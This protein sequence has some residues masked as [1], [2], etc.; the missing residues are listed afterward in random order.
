MITT[1]IPALKSPI[2]GGHPGA[3]WSPI[4]PLLEATTFNQSAAEDCP[5]EI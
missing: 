1:C 4:F 3:D 2:G 5:I